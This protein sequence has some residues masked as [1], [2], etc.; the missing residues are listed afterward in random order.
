MG[1]GQISGC[2]LEEE[3][4]AADEEAGGGEGWVLACLDS[5]AETLLAHEEVTRL[6]SGDRPEP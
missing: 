2:L 1:S 3:T 5:T 4:R 6:Q